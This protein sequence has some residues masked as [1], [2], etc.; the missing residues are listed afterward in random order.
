[1]LRASCTTF[2]RVV[3]SVL[4]L[5]S[6]VQTLTAQGRFI[7]TQSDLTSQWTVVSGPGT[8]SFDDSSSPV[9]GAHFSA[10][11]VYVMRLA[12]NDTQY[13]ASADVTITVGD[14]PIVNAPPVVDAG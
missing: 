9:T 12:A 10:T 2:Q 5:A 14:A 8:V 6:F 11:G 1:M 4:A 3:A 7:F 13:T